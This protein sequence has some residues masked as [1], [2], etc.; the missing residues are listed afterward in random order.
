MLKCPKINS[1]QPNCRYLYSAKIG[2]KRRLINVVCLSEPY[3]KDFGKGRKSL[4]VDVYGYG[5]KGTI[6]AKKLKIAPS[7]QDILLFDS[8][9]LA[10]NRTF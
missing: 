9:N 10:K 7:K 5:F 1:I 8:I 3:S 4:Y 2:G 6:L